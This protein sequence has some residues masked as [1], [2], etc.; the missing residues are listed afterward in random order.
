MLL[1][2]AGKVNNDFGTN[3]HEDTGELYVAQGVCAV[4]SCT[5]PCVPWLP[6]RGA[7]DPKRA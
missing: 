7:R 2:D 6:W 1:A 3:V 5:Q 4:A